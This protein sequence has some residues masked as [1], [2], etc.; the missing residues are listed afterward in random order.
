MKIDNADKYFSLYIRTRDDWTC[1]RCGGRY[2]PPTRSLHCSHFVGR[3]KENTR[4][5]EENCDALCWGCH[6]YFTSHPA[7]HYDWQV[8][9][10]GQATVDKIRLASSFYKK[11]D[12]VAEAL[13]WKQAVEKFPKH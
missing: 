11:K 1:K 5:M 13:Y 6:R 8:E 12:R 2:E 3:S 4:Y 9:Q 10:K 7:E